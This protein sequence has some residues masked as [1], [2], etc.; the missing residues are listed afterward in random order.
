M[1]FSLTMSADGALIMKQNGSYLVLECG[2][3]TTEKIQYHK[4]FFLRM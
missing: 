1:L 4:L 2:G 3:E